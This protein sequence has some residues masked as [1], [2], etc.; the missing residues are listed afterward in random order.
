MASFNRVLLV[1]NL[2]RDVELKYTS[3]GMA[4][5]TVSIAVNRKWK[6]ETG[7][8]KEE[9]TFVDCTAFGK[10]AETI[11]QYTKKGSPL[12]VEGRLKLDQWED[13]QTGQKRSKLGV[14]IETFQFLGGRESGEG[15]SRPATKPTA[16]PKAD[17]GN[18]DPEEDDKIPF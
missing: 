2:T 13:K 16:A 11:S 14:V 4:I 15:E 9:C 17:S 8:M 18:P 7:E 10:T 6:S 1:G 5:A 3:T 12:L